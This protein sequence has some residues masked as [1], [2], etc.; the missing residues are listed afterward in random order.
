MTFA[1]SLRRAV[2]KNQPP[3]FPLFFLAAM[4]LVA[5][6]IGW[7]VHLDSK[8]LD[9]LRAAA[10]RN[11]PDFFWADGVGSFVVALG[12]SLGGGSIV[13]LMF[14]NQHAVRPRHAW[15]GFATW[16]LTMT[17][18]NLWSST[19]P[20]GGYA[21]RTGVAWYNR[22]G[23]ID[24]QAWSAATGIAIGCNKG[25][26]SRWYFLRYQV[27]FPDRKAP[28]ANRA[29]AEGASAWLGK[30]IAV[31]A[32]I[33]ADARFTR[34]SFDWRCIA[35]HS[36]DLSLE[37]DKALV[38]LFRPTPERAKRI[39]KQSPVWGQFIGQ[40]AAEEAANPKR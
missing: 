36:R 39:E 24:R 37:E 38:A 40:V 28:L 17:G 12:L 4:A 34:L 19:W 15:V 8:S 35:Y 9:A 2:D 32:A 31:N 27:V 6:Q 22:H 13:A 23:P 3:D 5:I 33:P 25:K 21:D 20:V 29:S 1:N 10:D 14:S 30:V 18:A 26:K 16:A 11:R 7:A